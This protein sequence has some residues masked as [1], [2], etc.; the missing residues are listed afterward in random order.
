MAILQRKYKN[1]ILIGAA[2]PSSTIWAG[3]TA[4]SFVFQE[5]FLSPFLVRRV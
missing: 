3:A 2:G 1:A 4:F 5:A